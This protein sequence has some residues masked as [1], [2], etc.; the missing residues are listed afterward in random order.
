MGDL[1]D[2]EKQLKGIFGD[3][4]ALVGGAFNKTENVLKSMLGVVYDFYEYCGC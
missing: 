1:S 3:T 4:A 2:I